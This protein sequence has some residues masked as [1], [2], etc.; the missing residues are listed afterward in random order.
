MQNF[1]NG[2]PQPSGYQGT[3]YDSNHYRAFNNDQH[4][5][6]AIKFSD[7]SSVA[8]LAYQGYSEYRNKNFNLTSEI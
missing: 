5:N 4:N 6:G 8:D 1:L 3:Y 2:P 7:D